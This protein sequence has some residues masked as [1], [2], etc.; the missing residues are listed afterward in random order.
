MLYPFNYRSIFSYIRYQSNT[1]V[2]LSCTK[3]TQKVPKGTIFIFVGIGSAKNP[4][5][6]RLFSPLFFRGFPQEALIISI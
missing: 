1:C 6:L 3:K 2:S 4:L 5:L